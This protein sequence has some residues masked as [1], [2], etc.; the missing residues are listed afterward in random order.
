MAPTFCEIGGKIPQVGI[1]RHTHI[2]QICLDFDHGKKK[3][4]F[5]K[6]LHIG[7]CENAHWVNN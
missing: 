3:V 1:G 4:T 2:A 6:I 5:F 7:G